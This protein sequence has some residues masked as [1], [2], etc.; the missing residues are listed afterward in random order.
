MF[1][2]IFPAFLWLL[3]VHKFRIGQSEGV[4]TVTLRHNV[5]DLMWPRHHLIH[6]HLTEF[7]TANTFPL[8]FWY[9]SA[10]RQDRLFS[11]WVF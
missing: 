3:T 1:K 9:A 5:T 7:G 4:C 2:P 10:V 6:V 11:P 8:L